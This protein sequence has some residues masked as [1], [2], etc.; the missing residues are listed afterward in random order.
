MAYMASDTICSDC[1][2]SRSIHII[3]WIDS[4]VSYCIPRGRHIP[5]WLENAVAIFL[6]R[7]VVMLRCGDLNDEQDL[8][9]LEPRTRFFVQ[10]ARERGLRC[11]IL[12]IRNR[13]TE[14]VVLYWKGRIYYCEAYPTAGFLDGPK[15]ALV[16][17]KHTIKKYLATGGF[18]VAAGKAYWFWQKERALREVPVQFGFP[19]VVKPDAGTYGRHVTLAI[20]TVAQLREA[21][22]RALEYQPRFLIETYLP[23]TRAYRV[24]LIDK[25]YIACARYDTAHVVGDGV[26]S[27]HELL[28]AKNAHDSRHASQSHVSLTW[29]IPQDETM[30]SV[31]K[32]SGMQYEDVPSR[33]HRIELQKYPFLRLGAETIDQTHD[34]HPE[35]KALFES[36]AEYIDIHC[37][38]VDVLMEDIS[39]A[40][41]TQRSA[42]LEI[43]NLPG[44]DIHAE[45]DERVV[46]TVAD[47]LVNLFYK[48]YIS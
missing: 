8:N 35:N 47:A 3:T 30:L 15:A 2:A 18:P 24:T 48:Y 44:I 10:T 16:A 27:I 11:K 43:N 4:L 29:K 36:I 5:Y 42:V 31:L 33:G 32:E 19:L 13:Y 23:E 28:V 26:S 12:M 40:W 34:M 17:R 1:E 21:V 38:G 25:R 14:H 6:I 37:A 22:S 39:R 46:R 9:R 45:T 20:K 41:Y 7:A